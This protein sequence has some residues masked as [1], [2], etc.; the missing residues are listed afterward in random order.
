MINIKHWKEWVLRVSRLHSHKQFMLTL[1]KF[2]QKTLNEIV[3]YVY[4][5]LPHCKRLQRLSY[6]FAIPRFYLLNEV[7]VRKSGDFSSS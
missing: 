4:S 5:V 1:V 2:K 7:H 3:K 6:L